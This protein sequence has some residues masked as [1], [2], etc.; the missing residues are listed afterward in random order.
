MM[1]LPFTGLCSRHVCPSLSIDA[2]ISLE[3][4]LAMLVEKGKAVII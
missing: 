3:G 1:I 2:L 4:R